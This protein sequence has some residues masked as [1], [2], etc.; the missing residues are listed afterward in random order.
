MTWFFIDF[1]HRTYKKVVK[2][3]GENNLHAWKDEVLEETGVKLDKKYKN[4]MKKFKEL[5]KQKGFVFNPLDAATADELI[6]FTKGKFEGKIPRSPDFPKE[7]DVGDEVGRKNEG[8]LIA[9]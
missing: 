6:Y 4:R 1:T 2:T 7:E 9:F 3:V 5:E 8:F